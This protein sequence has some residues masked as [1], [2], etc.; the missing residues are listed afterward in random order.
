MT[1]V[2]LAQS[3][4]KIVF[5]KYGTWSQAQQNGIHHKISYYNKAVFNKN[6][7]IKIEIDQRKDLAVHRSHNF[8]GAMLLP[9]YIGQYGSLCP[10]GSR[11]R[12]KKW[13]LVIEERPFVVY[14]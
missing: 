2:I 14:L 1:Q 10:S 9:P 3:C 4:H 7:P 6:Y 11:D 13:Q 8:V 5:E 12:G